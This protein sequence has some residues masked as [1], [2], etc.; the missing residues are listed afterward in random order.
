[1]AVLYAF[2][3]NVCIVEHKIVGSDALR[4]SIT[5]FLIYYSICLSCIA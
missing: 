4:R 1:V 3:K 2:N 5:C